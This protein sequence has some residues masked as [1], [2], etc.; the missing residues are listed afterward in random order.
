VQLLRHHLIP[1]L[2]S[3]SMARSLC[4]FLAR[5]SANRDNLEQRSNQ[6]MSLATTE[7]IHITSEVVE[8][9]NSQVVIIQFLTHEI[10]SAVDARDLG[11]QLESLIQP[12][13]RRYYVLDFAGVRA[14]S[15]TALGELVTFVRV[16]K[17]VWICN[18][19]PTLRLGACLIGL[20][21]WAR[22]AADRRAAINLAEWTAQW[23]DEDTVDFPVRPR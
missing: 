11:D 8:K 12:H 21:N 10:T 6:A 20:E 7:Q 14:M 9:T 22:F 16:A 15:S 3:R 4:H 13:S 1:Q 5:I 19:D 18:L 23:D 2:I 17:P